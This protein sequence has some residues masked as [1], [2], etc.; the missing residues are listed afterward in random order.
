M[1]RLLFP[2]VFSIAMLSGG[3]ARAQPFFV[4]NSGDAGPGTLRAAIESANAHPGLDTIPIEATGT[5]EL[6]TELPAIVDEVSIAGAG[7]QALTIA[8]DASAPEFR[9]FSIGP[10]AAASIEGVA[11]SGGVARLGGGISS[12]SPLEL[13]D[14]FVTDNEAR[15]SG[16]VKA[17]AR[18]GGVSC[19]Q[20]LTVFQSVIR[21]N[22]VMASGGSEESFGAGGGINA[23]KGL[24]VERSTIAENLVQV[25]AE[26][27][28]FSGAQGGGIQSFGSGVEIEES[29]ISGNSVAASGAT[30]LDF[31]SGGGIDGK[32]KLTGST[33]TQNSVVGGGNETGANLNLTLSV[34]RDTI[35]AEPVGDRKSCHGDFTSGGYNLD[36]DGSCGFSL[37]SDLVGEV[38]G[39]DPVLRD[40][41]GPTP[42]HA[43][44]P[45][46][47]AIDRGSSFGSGV[48]QRGLPRPSDFP[49]VSNKEGGD[50]SDIG[51]FELQAP[52]AV[53]PGGGGGP[54]VVVEQPGDTT[55]PNTRI[56]R[57]PARLGYRRLARFRFAST[58]AQST[59][60]CKLDKKRWN[61]CANPFRRSVKPGRHVLMVRAI[62][63]F[64]NVDPTPAR[65]GWRVKPLS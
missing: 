32:V 2:L 1:R 43:L 52:A 47:I 46:S 59:F 14:V 40:N 20:D 61:A 33:V 35:V 65:F 48:D 8:R 24:I 29:T 50:G 25:D 54:A 34:V 41:G 64:G 11:I 36:E 27:G 44:L 5:I 38:A 7:P 19:S 18:G 39:L 26:G 62:D 22:R 63:R 17:I 10:S 13:S 60:Q 49:E 55:A 42:T 45:G 15:R 58:E 3:V 57:G 21:G 16:G 37:G 23:A 12:E 4:Y 56:V 53:A 31:P 9:I 30:N 6:E 51:A 28:M